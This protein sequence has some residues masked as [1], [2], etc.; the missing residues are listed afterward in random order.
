MISVT[1]KQFCSWRSPDRCAVQS[2]KQ[3]LVDVEQCARKIVFKTEEISQF[4]LTVLQF[5][6]PSILLLLLS[7]SFYRSLQVPS[8]STKQFLQWGTD[9]LLNITD[10][11]SISVHGMQNRLRHWFSLTSL[12]KPVLRNHNPHN[13]PGC[14]ASRAERVN[15]AA[16]NHG[17]G[18]SYDRS[19]DRIIQVLVRRVAAVSNWLWLRLPARTGNRPC[20][21]RT[22][23]WKYGG[24]RTYVLFLTSPLNMDLL[25]VFSHHH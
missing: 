14:C 23:L 24:D 7:C 16:V 6:Y 21:R 9:R 12:S 11:L 4:R 13:L 2:V 18:S 19:L 3:T 1:L 5:T 8:T 25:S 22:H 10:N 17:G 15:L 20:N